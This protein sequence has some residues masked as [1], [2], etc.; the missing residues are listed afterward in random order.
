MY[1]SIHKHAAAKY[2]KCIDLDTKGIIPGVIWADDETGWY[3]SY[4]F[5]EDGKHTFTMES[6]KK[7][8]AGSSKKGNIKLVE[9]ED[10]WNTVE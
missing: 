9:I 4:D 10:Y 8:I 2:H 1:L 6:G 3:Y 7:E 5:D